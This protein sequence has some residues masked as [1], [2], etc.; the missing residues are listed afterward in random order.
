MFPD[1]RRF[2][3]L[4]P[5]LNAKDE[6]PDCGRRQFREGRPAIELGKILT[7]MFFKHGNKSITRA[8]AIGRYSYSAVVSLFILDRLVNAGEQPGRVRIGILINS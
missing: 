1:N 6:E 4:E 8:R 5:V 7:A 3:E 2:I